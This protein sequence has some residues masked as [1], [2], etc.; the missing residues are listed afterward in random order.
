MLQTHPVEFMKHGLSQEDAIKR[1]KEATGG[2]ISAIKYLKEVDLALVIM[3]AS[4]PPFDQVSLTL[5]GTLESHKTKT[6]IVANKTD[7][8]TSN[9]RLIQDTFPHLRVVPVSALKG[10]GIDELY[11]EIAS[12]A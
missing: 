3:D 4:L 12:V 10:D 7:L 9:V 2:I 8:D 5:L 6:I 1:A 11:Q